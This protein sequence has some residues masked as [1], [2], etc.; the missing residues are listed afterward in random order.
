MR[1]RGRSA[2]G[3]VARTRTTP[4][5]CRP[6]E[7]P[8]RTSRQEFLRAQAGS[9]PSRAVDVSIRARTPVDLLAAPSRAAREAPHGSV[10]RAWFGSSVV[11]RLS[12]RQGVAHRLDSIF[13]AV[14]VDERHSQLPRRRSP[15]RQMHRRFS[16]NH[17]RAARFSRSS[18]FN[19]CCSLVASPGAVPCLARLNAPNFAMPAA[20]PILLAIDAGPGQRAPISGR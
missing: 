8:N 16:E 19:R 12:N 20:Q 7:Q 4:A 1:S 3:L 15:P 13:A 17:I 18:K 11:G 9:E 2:S 14:R 10:C 6:L 5:T